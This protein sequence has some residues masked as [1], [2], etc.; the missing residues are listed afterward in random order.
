MER[1]FFRIQLSACK[2]EVCVR[3]NQPWKKRRIREVCVRFRL[4]TS[5]QFR[6]RWVVGIADVSNCLFIKN[7]MRIGQRSRTDS[8]N[9]RTDSQPNAASVLRSWDRHDRF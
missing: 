5:Q 3:F 1:P 6:G 8:V 7:D 4:T 2:K 9:Q